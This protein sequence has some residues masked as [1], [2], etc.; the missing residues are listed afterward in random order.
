MQFEIFFKDTSAMP[1]QVSK[2]ILQ[3]LIKKN[4]KIPRT[5]FEFGIYSNGLATKIR[6]SEFTFDKATYNPNFYG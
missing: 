1:I 5:K 4:S 3:K 6:S 2:E